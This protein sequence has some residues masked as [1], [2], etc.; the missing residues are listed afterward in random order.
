KAERVVVCPPSPRPL[1]LQAAVLACAARAP[2]FVWHSDKDETELRDWLSVWHTDEVLAVGNVSEQCKNL[3]DVRLRSFPDEKRTFS[4]ALEFQARRGSVRTLVVANPGDSGLA[5]LAPWVTAQKRA[6]L[7]LT[8]AK[9]DA[10]REVVDTALKRSA[11]RQADHLLIIADRTAIPMEK[12][13]NPLVG[14]DAEIEMEPLTP[15]GA[16]PFEFA[17]G[18]VFGEDYGMVA[19]QLARQRLLKSGGPRKALVVSNPGGGLPL[20]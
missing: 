19:L 4:A 13:G 15:T 16:A 7:L 12:R 2:L 18:R 1:L 8:N 17:T 6:V 5:T 14:K 9:G 20:L 3:P 10:V 11:V